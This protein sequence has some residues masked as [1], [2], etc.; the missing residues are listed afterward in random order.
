MDKH[1]FTIASRIDRPRRP[2]F[3]YHRLY[4]KVHHETR[5]SLKLILQVL[6]TAARVQAAKHTVTVLAARPQE[7]A[8]RT[9]V[10]S[11]SAKRTHHHPA[12]LFQGVK[13]QGSHTITGQHRCCRVCCTI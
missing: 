8:K 5:R 12:R 11:T 3:A 4:R 10:R 7:V 9:R 2:S 1:P 13:D 6:E